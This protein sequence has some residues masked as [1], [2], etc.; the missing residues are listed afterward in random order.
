MPM[1]TFYYLTLSA[2]TEA[3]LRQWASHNLSN[4][5]EIDE[6]DAYGG[7]GSWDEATG[8]RRKRLSIRVIGNKDRLRVREAFDITDTR[9]AEHFVDHLVER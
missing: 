3:D 6:Q 1:A 5:F 9:F 2:V 4:P 7:A 8:R